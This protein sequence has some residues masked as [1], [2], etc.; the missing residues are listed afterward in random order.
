MADAYEVAFGWQK[1]I[2]PKTGRST[3]CDTSTPWWRKV[4]N[5]VTEQVGTAALEYVGVDPKDA[6]RLTDAG[7]AAVQ[8]ETNKLSNHD[9]KKWF[10]EAPNAAVLA[11]GIAHA[12]MFV[13]DAWRKVDHDLPLHAWPYRKQALVAMDVTPDN[14][15]GSAKQQVEAAYTVCMYSFM[16]GGI[17][18]GYARHTIE[19]V[20]LL[21]YQT[22]ALLTLLE[23]IENRKAKHPNVKN[24]P[25]VAAQWTL[26][27]LGLVKAAAATLPAAAPPPPSGPSAAPSPPAP[28]PEPAVPAAPSAPS[29][30][31]V[32]APAETTTPTPS[33]PPTAAG[34]GPTI[35]DPASCVGRFVKYTGKDGYDGGRIDK[36][37]GLDF[38]PVVG[39]GFKLVTV[40]T[41][42]KGIAR[43][44]ETGIARLGE[45]YFPTIGALVEMIN[46]GQVIWSD[47]DGAPVAPPAYTAPTAAGAGIGDQV[48][49]LKHQKWAHVEAVGPCP[50][51]TC[52]GL[53]FDDGKAGAAMDAE[54]AK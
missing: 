27:T 47:K 33:A 16:L 38:H 10:N 29:A 54:I 31:A 4:V 9:L 44:G 24:A 20:L 13:D 14:F 46:D 22:S 50:E 3:H 15:A 45:T 25:A 53:R 41:G 19:A 52:Y 7:I 23:I 35:A 8:A 51:G 21:Y 36:I 42:E 30:P 11:W 40:R 49:S 32:A 37:V 43:L 5:W 6:R 12:K 39:A 34:S 28:S 26:E 2:D 17:G 18:S 48:W 1:K